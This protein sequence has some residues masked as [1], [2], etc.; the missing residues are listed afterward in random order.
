MRTDSFDRTNLQDIAVVT[1]VQEGLHAKGLPT[2][3]HASFLEKRISHFERMVARAMSGESMSLAEGG[4]IYRE[5]R[6]RDV[7]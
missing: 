2:P 3:I 5:G 1:R 4:P 6:V 7:A